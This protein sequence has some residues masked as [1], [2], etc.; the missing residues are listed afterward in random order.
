MKN[1][2]AGALQLSHSEKPADYV[3]H[4]YLCARQIEKRELADEALEMGVVH[5]DRSKISEKIETRLQCPVLRAQNR[6]RRHTS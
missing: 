5:L 6:V 2:E 1:P 3:A 4:G